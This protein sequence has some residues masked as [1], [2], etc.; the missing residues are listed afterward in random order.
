MRGR[1]NYIS[2]LC[3]R[4]SARDAQLCAQ[5]DAAWFDI[6]KAR[7]SGGGSW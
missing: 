7:A 1:P 5:T 4:L 2:Q 3:P 6:V